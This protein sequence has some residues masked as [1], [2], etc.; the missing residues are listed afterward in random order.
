[1]NRHLTRD[2]ETKIR[3]N[4]FRAKKAMAH[5]IFAE[6]IF[7]K[8]DEDEPGHVV[9]RDGSVIVTGPELKYAFRHESVTVIE[10]EK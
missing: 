2:I 9:P 7:E 5:S 4:G 3:V 8:N 6:S 1:M 10:L